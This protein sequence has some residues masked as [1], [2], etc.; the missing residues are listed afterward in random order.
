MNHIF[1]EPFT[2]SR[3]TARKIIALSMILQTLMACNYQ[4]IPLLFY[5]PIFYCDTS[6]GLVKC[7]EVD[8]CLESTLKYQSEY[9]FGS[10]PQ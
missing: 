2:H 8:A 7:E 10:I 5:R 6:T 4:T 3:P 9:T 1:V